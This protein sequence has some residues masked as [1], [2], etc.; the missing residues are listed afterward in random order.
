MVYSGRGR[1]KGWLWDHRAWVLLASWAVIISW[2]IA[3]YLNLLAFPIGVLVTVAVLV[4]IFVILWISMISGSPR[5]ESAA[6]L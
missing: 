5:P 4:S 1:R 3:E 2:L 6:T